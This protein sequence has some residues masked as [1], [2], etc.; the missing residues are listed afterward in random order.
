MNID[1]SDQNRRLAKFR[2]FQRRERIIENFLE[3]F[4]SIAR[5]SLDKLTDLQ[6]KIVYSLEYLSATDEEKD[7]LWDPEEY[8]YY[9]NPNLQKEAVIEV[10]VKL[11]KQYV[12]FRH[13]LDQFRDEINELH[14]LKRKYTDE[15]EIFTNYEDIRDDMIDRQNELTTLKASLARSLESTSAAIV[16]ADAKRQN[17]DVSIIVSYKSYVQ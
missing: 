12:W 16:E 8:E 10:I 7:P 17:A 15:I 13:T 1:Y 14:K 11:Q 9:V 5:D 3:N 2:E 4:S 6:G